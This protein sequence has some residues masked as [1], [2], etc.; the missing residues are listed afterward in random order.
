LDLQFVCLHNQNTPYNL[1]L[2]M[3]F[4]RI[5]LKNDLALQQKRAIS[6]AVHEALVASIGIPSDDIFHIIEA[7]GDNLI[8]NPHFM[9]MARDEGLVMIEIHL[10]IGRT[11]EKKQLLYRT[12]AERLAAV[13]VQ[14]DNL[15]VHLV[16]TTRDNWSFGRGLAQYVQAPAQA[17]LVNTHPDNSHPPAAVPTVQL[18]DEMARITRWDFAPG[19]ATGQHK[20]Q[21]PYF[22]VMLTE[23][24]LQIHNGSTATQTRLVAGQSYR[25]PAGVEH[26]VINASAQPLAFVEI[27]VK[28]ALA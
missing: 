4:L 21:W 22:V 19:A 12:I 23:G 16:E 20:H 25:R 6:A 11:T 5:S 1:E 26:D 2:N 14:P 28:Q 9:G 18:D 7:H 27:E 13:G 8:F 17:A 10:A 24:T 3:P 15:F